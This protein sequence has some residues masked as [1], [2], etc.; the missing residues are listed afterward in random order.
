AAGARGGGVQPRG[1][2][3]GG[4]GTAG[5]DD[6]RSAARGRAFEQRR[7]PE[8]AGREAVFESFEGWAEA[9][10]LAR[11]LGC[12]AGL[13]GKQLPNPGPGGHGNAPRQRRGAQPERGGRWSRSTR[14][15]RRPASL[16]GVVFG[17]LLPSSL[18]QPRIAVRWRQLF[19]RS[20]SDVSRAGT[21]HQ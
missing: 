6:V 17:L 4:P 20:S 21:T 1:V 13:A 9:R 18:P 14:K 19:S 10:R 2:G 16:V 3:R 12:P 15:A 11:R 5:A 7:G 8:R